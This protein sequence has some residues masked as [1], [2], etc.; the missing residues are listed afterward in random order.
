MTPSCTGA[1]GFIPPSPSPATATPSDASTRSAEEPSQAKCWSGRTKVT[2][3]RSPLGERMAKYG[4]PLACWGRSTLRL[5]G[6]SGEI[7]EMLGTNSS[8]LV[9]GDDEK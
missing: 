8:R 5:S 6:F 9:G 3:T 7:R 2:M 1:P 4:D